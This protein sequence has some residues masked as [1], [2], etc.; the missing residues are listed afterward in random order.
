M[1]TEKVYGIIIVSYILLEMAIPFVTAGIA[2]SFLPVKCGPIYVIVGFGISIFW[3]AT[4]V[5]GSKL[6]ARLK[7]F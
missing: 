7:T 6:L 4:L 3:I 5:S 1:V 2:A